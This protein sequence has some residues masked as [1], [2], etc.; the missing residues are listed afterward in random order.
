MRQAIALIN[1]CLNIR[2]QMGI[3][4]IFGVGLTLASFLSGG[5]IAFIVH[6]TSQR[7]HDVCISGF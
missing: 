4:A 1:F 2:F 3:Y 5:I 6:S 7:M